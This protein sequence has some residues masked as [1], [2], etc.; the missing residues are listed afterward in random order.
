MATVVLPEPVPPAIPTKSV[1]I[2]CGARG[3]R[4]LTRLP[5][6]VFETNLSAIPTPRQFP[7]SSCYQ[8]SVSAPPSG[9]NSQYFLAHARKLR[10]EH[11]NTAPIHPDERCY[12][13][14]STSS[15]DSLDIAYLFFVHYTSR[16]HTHIKK[17]IIYICI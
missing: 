10:V 13:I 8:I 4:T 14:S 3:S 15:T 17:M 5:S 2:E 6:L 16:M 1:F 12:I 7:S 11:S 9:T